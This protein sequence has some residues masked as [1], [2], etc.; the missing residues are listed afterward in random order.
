M[1]KILYKK[2]LFIFI[3][4]ILIINTTTYSQTHYFRHYEVESGLSNN[5][6]LC[7]AQDNLGFM[8]FGTRDGV[9][10]FDGF[11]F[12]VY[13]FPENNQI[14]SLHLNN[15]GVLI[16]TTEKNIYEYNAVTDSFV[17]IVSPKKYPIYIAISDNE[18]NI[19]YNANL[20]LSK[21]SKKN[22]TV[23]TYDL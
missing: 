5:A 20:V 10:R 17:L 23:K 6:V 14:H 22:K 12:K 1:L 4:A 18:E 13:R 8:W 9:N 11:N 15:S 19:W 16:A 21:Y 7:S 2:K 3:L